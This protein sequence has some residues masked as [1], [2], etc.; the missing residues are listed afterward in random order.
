M[1]RIF[2]LAT[3]CFIIATCA[4]SQQL[5][6]VQTADSTPKRR[7]PLPQT[8]LWLSRPTLF[9]PPSQAVY[10]QPFELPGEFFGYEAPMP[11]TF[12]GGFMEK[13]TDLMTPLLL[14]WE[15]ESR[16]RPFQIVLGS[17]SAGGAVYAAYRHIKK[18]GLFK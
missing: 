17:L 18:Y 13:R 2:T 3:L 4:S 16:M 6:S 9:T 15:S 5:S 14:Q 1:K 8:E 11:P 7:F 12:V 10:P